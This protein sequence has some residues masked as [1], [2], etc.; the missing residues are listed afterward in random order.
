M[1]IQTHLDNTQKIKNAVPILTHIAQNKIHQEH[2]R[3]LH[4]L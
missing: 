1:K 2:F 4:P 3:F